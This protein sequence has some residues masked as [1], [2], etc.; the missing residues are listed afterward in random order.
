MALNDRGR[1]LTGAVVEG[2]GGSELVAAG[3]GGAAAGGGVSLVLD[4]G[5]AGGSLVVP[6]GARVSGDLAEALAGPAA[7]GQVAQAAPAAAA[8]PI[9]RVDTVE[10]EVVVARA[11][12]TQVSLS[13]GSPVFQGDVLETG[14]GASLGI[15]FVDDTTFSLGEDA[16]MV[17]DELIYD[18]STNT[19]S[20]AFSVVQGVFV[21]VSGEIA[22]SGDQAM[23]VTTPVGSIGIRGTT[24]AAEIAAEVEQSTITLLPDEDGSTGEI[25]FTNGGGTQF[26]NIAYQQITATSFSVAPSAPEIKTAAEVEAQYG[27]ALSALP[28]QAA[29]GAQDDGTAGEPGAADG[30]DGEGEDEGGEGEDG[31]V[32]P[33]A[34][35]ELAPAAGEEGGDGEGEGG[36]N[37]FAGDDGA[38][39]SGPGTDS[40]LLGDLT[41]GTGSDGLTGGGGGGGG[42]GGAGGGGG[43]GTT[44]ITPTPRPRRRR[45][46]SIR[47]P[48]ATSSPAPRAATRTAPSRSISMPRSPTSTAPRRCRSRLP[49]FPTTRP[50]TCPRA[51]SP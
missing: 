47:T 5:S 13:S 42:G 26:I 2:S 39:L 50:S 45:S 33:E 12:G 24:V 6:G 10:G 9:G 1:D 7:P 29:A 30:E 28:A 49:A 14:S 31:E 8:Q 38:P 41:G 18:P 32:D 51:A 37:P 25:V 17:L 3:P 44:F 36:D 4:A 27:A 22:K 23:V 46:T 15:V 11:D 48:P 16:R 43:G 40:G 35:G 34:L 19:G 21:F 20:S